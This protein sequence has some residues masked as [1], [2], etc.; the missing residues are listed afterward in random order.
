MIAR[1]AI[2]RI[3]DLAE[4]INALCDARAL[5][6]DHPTR[7][8]MHRYHGELIARGVSDPDEIMRVLSGALEAGT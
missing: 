1:D 6:L 5:P 2:G 3:M 8:R 7:V 4:R